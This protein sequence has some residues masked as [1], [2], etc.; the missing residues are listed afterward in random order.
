MDKLN[1]KDAQEFYLEEDTSSTEQSKVNTISAKENELKDLKEINGLKEI[2][3]LN[4]L[5]E[6]DCKNILKE[7]SE[8]ADILQTLEKRLETENN[9]KI[10]KNDYELIEKET[11][12]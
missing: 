12:I 3:E 8:I 1:G 9:N 10:L 2:K 7:K 4:E 5:N 6:I 11:N